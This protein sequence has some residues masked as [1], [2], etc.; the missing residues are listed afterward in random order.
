MLCK[1]VFGQVRAVDI[2]SSFTPAI[3]YDPMRAAACE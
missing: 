2:P 3:A 1:S